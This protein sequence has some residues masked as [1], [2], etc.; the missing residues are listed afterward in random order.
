MEVS[1]GLWFELAHPGNVDVD[2]AEVLT[3]GRDALVE[4]MID[5]LPF[6]DD[7][8]PVLLRTALRSYGG[9]V[10]VT[11]DEWLVSG[12]ITRAQAAALLETALIAIVEE[13]LPAMADARVADEPKPVAPAVAGV[14]VSAA[15]VASLGAARAAR[16]PSRVGEPRSRAKAVA[17]SPASLKTRK[18]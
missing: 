10:R 14:D 12:S 3:R 6:P 18:K 7:V 5:E 8:D 1:G 15:D 13:V 11:S 2:V 16:S 17:K 4:R 9:L